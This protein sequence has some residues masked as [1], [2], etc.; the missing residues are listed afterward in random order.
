MYIRIHILLLALLALTGC[1]KD[2]DTVLP[3][4]Q[5]QFVTF[6]TGSHLPELVS[7]EE[8]EESTSNPE[9][10]TTEGN[11][12][13]RY[14][15]HFYDSD[16]SARPQVEKGD[17]VTLTYWVY[18]FS[19]TQPSIYGSA[20]APLWTNDPLLQPALE[21]IGY[22][23]S[24]WSFEPFAMKV[25]AG[26][27]MRGADLSLPGC[28]ERDTVEV[29]MTYNMAYGASQIG[30]VPSKSPIAFFCVIDSVEKNS[31]PNSVPNQS[32]GHT[33]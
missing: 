24:E 17:R 33:L 13:Y 8:A 19:G 6:L 22:D 18:Y 10:Y 20:T 26:E 30:L 21:N 23:T 5:D 32:E 14:I 4:Q 31:Q 2:E 12:A 11:T 9:F 16:R 27:I 3:Q 29:Y 28:R 15:R 1:K 25:G 7:A